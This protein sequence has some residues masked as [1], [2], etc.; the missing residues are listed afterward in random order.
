MKVAHIIHKVQSLLQEE[1]ITHLVQFVEKQK[2][3]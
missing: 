1:M 2:W 3:P